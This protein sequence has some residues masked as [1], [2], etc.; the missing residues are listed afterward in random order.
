MDY[1]S[2]IAGILGGLLGSLVT[3]FVSLHILRKQFVRE[4]KT[5]R[6]NRVS[7]IMEKI[8]SSIWTILVTFLYEYALEEKVDD[9]FFDFPPG[10][11]RGDLIS[12]VS[13]EKMRV[14]S[15]MQEAERMLV[16]QRSLIEL[17]IGQEGASAFDKVY[18]LVPEI[19]ESLGKIEKGNRK[20]RDVRPNEADNWDEYRNAIHELRNVLWS[21]A[22][23]NSFSIS[24][25]LFRVKSKGNL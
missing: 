9:E 4:E 15:R 16:Q 7:E 2:W 3:G 21:Y 24:F 23:Y 19:K 10:D 1:S 22:G 8:E 5:V 11:K 20:V 25:F 17:F 6:E 18:G 13:N 12:N 14:A